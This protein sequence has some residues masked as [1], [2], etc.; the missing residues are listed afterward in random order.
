MKQTCHHSVLTGSNVDRHRFQADP[1]P[2]S[3]PTSFDADPDPDPT[4]VYTCRKIRNFYIVLSF[5]SAS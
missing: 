3:D 4:Q 5:S 1:G 2:D